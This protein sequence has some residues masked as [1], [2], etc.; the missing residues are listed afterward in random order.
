MKIIN[1]DLLKSAVNGALR[2]YENENKLILRRFTLK[3]EEFFKKTLNYV[4]KPSKAKAS[5][6][7]VIDF[8]SN[9]NRIEFSA[10]TFVSSTRTPCFFDVYQDGELIAHNGY[11]IKK[12]GSVNVKVDFKQ[13]EKRIKIYLPCLFEAQFENF[14][15]DD[16]ATFVRYEHSMKWLFLG[17]SITQGYVADYPS[18]TYANQVANA[19][20]A[21]AVNQSIGGAYFMAE[22]LDEDVNFNPDIVT[23]AYGTNDWAHGYDIEN[24]ANKYFE[25]LVK[26]FPNKKIICI[27][28]IWRGDMDIRETT[29]TM[30]FEQVQGLLKGICKKF[31]IDTVDGSKLVDGDFSN[32]IE[33]RL[34]PNDKG[35]DQYAKNLIK[36]LKALGI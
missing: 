6:S 10:K 25:K 2:V 35:F 24:N 20:D 18:R 9:T 31:N 23:V 33:D 26:I 19:F 32:F 14:L 28:P 21:N 12:D 15:I 17:D 4:D 29:E 30:P 22:D 5:T 1:F 3:Q 8:I 27:T 16:E 34:H 11:N 36:E 7:M 13:G